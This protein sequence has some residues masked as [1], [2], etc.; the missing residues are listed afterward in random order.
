MGKNKKLNLGILSL[1]LISIGGGVLST[2]ETIEDAQREINDHN[3][4][5]GSEEGTT[6]TGESGSSF[7]TTKDGT[8]LEGK[9]KFDIKST[10]G[11]THLELDGNGVKV[12][13]LSIT[14][15]PKED[16]THERAKGL[17]TRKASDVNVNNLNVDVT[18]KDTTGQFS[19]SADSNAS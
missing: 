14:I 17:I 13:D 7:V 15:A 2:A 6:Y 4:I 5:I 9:V 3:K 11:E 18:F 19:G 1:L 10:G 16:T 8:K 12:D